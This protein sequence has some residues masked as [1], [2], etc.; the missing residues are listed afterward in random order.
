MILTAS[1]NGPYGALWQRFAIGDTVTVQTAC[2][3]EKLA[4]AKYI[5]GCGDILVEH[6]KIADSTDWMHQI[7][8][9]NPRT[10]VGWRADGTLVMYVAEGRNP[11]TADGLTLQMA[12]EEMLRQGC[13][14]AVNMDGG[15]SSIV[16]VRLPG[17]TAVEALNR[18]S[19]GGQRQCA[20]YLLLVTDDQP[21]G[22]VRNWHLKQNNLTVL[23]GQRVALS[24]FGTDAALYPAGEPP[25]H[26]A[27]ADAKGP[28]EGNV[29]TAPDTSGSHRITMWGGGAVGE[30]E[31][32]VLTDPSVLKIVD[33]YGREPKSVLLEQGESLN[34]RVIASHNG[35]VIPADSSAIRYEMSAPLGKVDADGV[36]TADAL[37]GTRGTLTMRIGGYTQELQV[38]VI[39]S[40]TDAS[41]HRM[42]T[43]LDFLK[44]GE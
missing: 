3:D 16:G 36:F 32:K 24:V 17:Q 28:L 35:T 2:A 42:K 39:R 43:A 44:V 15:G 12:A 5:T 29:F 6:G 8:G 1:V 9:S 13:E 40:R 14:F 31:I 34:L 33:R 18:P 11:G 19:D 4:Q 37:I 27:Y 23:P 30:G 25:K 26:L 7:G 20:A 21:D 38:T 22:I 10:M 41:E